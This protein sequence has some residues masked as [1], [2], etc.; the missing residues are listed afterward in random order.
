METASFA[1]WSPTSRIVASK[2][3][4][5]HVFITCYSQSLISTH[6]QLWLSTHDIVFLGSSDTAHPKLENAPTH[7]S[8]FPIQIQQISTHHR[9]FCGSHF[10]TLRKCASESLLETLA[11]PAGLAWWWPTALHSSAFVCCCWAWPSC[12]G[13]R[14]SGRSESQPE[15]W[16]GFGWK[17]AGSRRNVILFAWGYWNQRE[18]VW[19]NTTGTVFASC[20][21]L[22]SLMPEKS[23]KCLENTEARSCVRSP[24]A[25][26][27]EPSRPGLR[28]CGI[29][30][31]VLP[32]QPHT[33]SHPIPLHLPSGYD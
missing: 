26:A 27:S 28:R 10:L 25:R 14:W 15:P 5:Q 17:L 9:G 32:C 30:P 23:W 8:S 7:A 2:L 19:E 29:V 12:L 4:K 16:M 31:G 6:P 20:P 11:Y 22:N 21:S 1:C 13:S 18:A 3:T 24:P 33:W